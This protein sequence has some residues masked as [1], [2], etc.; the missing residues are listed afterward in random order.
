VLQLEATETLQK[1][2]TLCQNDRQQQAVE[3]RLDGCTG[4]ETGARIGVS[5]LEDSSNRPVA[6]TGQVQEEVGPVLRRRR[7]GVVSETPQRRGGV[8]MWQREVRGGAGLRVPG[9]FAYIISCPFRRNSPMLR[10][11]IKARVL[12][13]SEKP[14]DRRASL[15]VV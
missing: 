7:G 5:N 15:V 1:V 8:V 4:E 11:E 9:R 3:A 2:Y 12:D 6:A 10:D 13:S 14:G